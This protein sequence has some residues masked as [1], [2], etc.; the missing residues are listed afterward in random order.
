MS[1]NLKS[2]IEAI[3]KTLLT[4]FAIFGLIYLVLY[5]IENYG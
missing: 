4:S 5:I 2:W 3:V 1:D